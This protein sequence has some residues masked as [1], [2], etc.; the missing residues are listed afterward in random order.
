MPRYMETTKDD[1]DRVPSS[2][3]SELEYACFADAWSEVRDVLVIDLTRYTQMLPDEFSECLK[4]EPAGIY[5]YG[6]LNPVVAFDSRYPLFSLKSYKAQKN[7]AMLIPDV[8]D[9]N[10]FLACNDSIVDLKG[11]VVVKKSPRTASFYKDRCSYNYSAIYL[12]VTDVWDLL[13]GLHRETNPTANISRNALYAENYVRDD[14]DAKAFR[15]DMNPGVSTVLRKVL[16]FVGRDICSLY[17]LRLNNTTLHVEK[18]N[19]FRVI[20][21]YRARFE[22]IE[23]K[24]V[25]DYG[26]CSGS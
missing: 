26:F 1:Q 11:K 21:Y 3:D 14:I 24:I 7:N 15:T 25:Q 18:G 23:S 19:D 17:S 20:E 12:L 8:A 2:S 6:Q 4:P 22:E 13:S 10:S 16:D 9:Y 5:L